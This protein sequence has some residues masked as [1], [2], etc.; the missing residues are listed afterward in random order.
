MYRSFVRNSQMLAVKRLLKVP[1]CKQSLNPLC[2]SVH[3]SDFSTCQVD[4]VAKIKASDPLT[5]SYG[6]YHDYL[7]ISL[8]ERCNL[9]CE[10][11]MPSDGVPLTPKDKLL[12]SDEILYLAKLFVRQGVTKIRLTGGEPTVRKDIINIIARL[13][14]LDGLKTIAMTTNGLTLTRQLV[15]LQKAGLNLLN[16]SLD[17][18]QSARY[19]KVTRRKGWERVIAGIDLAIQLGFN[20]V[21]VNCVVMRG[22]NDDEICDFARFTLDR[23]V[24][25]RFIE[26]M[27]FSGNGWHDNRMVSF[28]EMLSILTK[29]FPGFEALKNE[30]N[31][32]SKAYKVPGSKGKLGFITSM[33]NNFCSTCN[34]IRLTADGN[35]K[36]CLFGNAEISLRD[37]VRNNSSEDDIMTMVGLALQRKK[38]QH[39]G[40]SRT[41]NKNINS[42]LPNTSFLNFIPINHSMNRF[43]E[44]RSISYTHGNRNMNIDSKHNDKLTHVD[45]AGKANMVNV[46]KK[47][48][49][50]RS[51]TACGKVLV[52]P[53]VSAL[54]KSN[55]MKK[56]DVLTVA[57]I[58]GIQGAKKTPD[59]IPLCHNIF[60]SGIKLDA[61]L[62]DGTDT[63]II[64]ATVESE[65]KTGVEMEAL[66][67]VTIAALTVYDMCKAVTHNIVIRDIKLMEK[68]GGVRGDFKRNSED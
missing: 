3:T 45:A 65:G 63:I 14:E 5:D 57:R 56:G 10:Y 48:V 54:I 19:E 46:G 9:R 33:S 4:S 29:E 51:A 18:L 20:P 59:L 1:G 8:T 12:T 30:P 64:T 62:E 15:G 39:A 37:A 17:T 16:I 40:V 53:K 11:C 61:T 23:N 7:R 43:Y 58:A 55:S 21:K 27:P 60:L 42:F 25:V 2:L 68:T 41:A 26:Y 36:V 24:D 35:I 66:T 52:G 6:R 22:F 44:T 28:K 38:K 49:S 50:S 31:D 34:R 67:A 47:I 32:T 13:K